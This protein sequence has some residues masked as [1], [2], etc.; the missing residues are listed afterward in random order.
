[1]VKVISLSDDAY[2]ELKRLKGAGSFSEI[3][4]EI[5]KEKKKDSLLEIA[6]TWSKEDAD[7]IKKE[8]YEDRKIPSRRFR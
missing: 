5:V 1:M 3:I 6:G 7:K 2:N 8:I 4:I